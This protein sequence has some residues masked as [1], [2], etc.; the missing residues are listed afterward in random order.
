M[1]IYTHTCTHADRSSL[2]THHASEINGEN[3]EEEGEDED[4]V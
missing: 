3:E 2:S 1:Y 4:E